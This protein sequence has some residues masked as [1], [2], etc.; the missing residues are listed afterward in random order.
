MEAILTDAALSMFD[1]MLGA[2]CRRADRA[3]KEN[4]VE[5]ARTICAKSSSATL[6]CDA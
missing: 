1:K 3:R 4:V 6:R 2:I 5:R